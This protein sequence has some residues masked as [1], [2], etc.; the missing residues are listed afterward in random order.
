ILLFLGLAALGRPFS[1]HS[2]VLRGELP[3]MLFVCVVAGSVLHDGQLSRSDC[4]FLLLLA[5]L[6]LV[7]IVLFARLADRQGNDSLT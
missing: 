5:V 7:F 4:F 6:W 1:V 3:L 2:D